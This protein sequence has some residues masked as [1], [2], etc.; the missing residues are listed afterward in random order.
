[1]ADYSTD[2]QQ[3]DQVLILAP[4]STTVMPLMLAL[5]ERVLERG[6]HPHLAPFLSGQDDNFV[7]LFENIE[8]IKLTRNKG[9]L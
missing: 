6:G 9:S 8:I 4:A 1:L 2:I 5:Y 3:D 7:L